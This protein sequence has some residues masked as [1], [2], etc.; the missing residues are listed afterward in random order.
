MSPIANTSGWPG[1]VQSSRTTIRP[2]RSHVAPLASA[3]RAASGE[4]CTPA[5]QILVRAAR[6]S[7]SRPPSGPRHRTRPPRSPRSPS[8]WSRR[9]A[10]A[11]GRPSPRAGPRTRPGSSGH[12]DED[13]LGLGGVDPA[14]VARPGPAG[15]LG[16]LPGDL[17][18]GRPGADH[19]ERQPAPGAS[20]HP[21]SPPSRRRRRSARAAPARRRSSSCP[22]R[23]GRTPGGRSTPAPRRWPRS[24]CRT[25]WHRLVGP[26][27][28]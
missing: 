11:A 6:R 18:A 12:V 13:D 1:R 10:A 3:S 27:R 8:G 4:A 24:A 9:G 23:A 2:A 15:Q 20:G 25:W 16:D 19:H 22:A 28:R 17:D 7:A 26:V 21:R 5:A 14:E